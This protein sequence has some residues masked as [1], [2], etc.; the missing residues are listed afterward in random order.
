MYQASGLDRSKMGNSLHMRACRGR[1]LFL[2]WGLCFSQSCGLLLF[3]KV[4]S[5]IQSLAG[6]GG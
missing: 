5:C 3:L 1:N 4:H 2:Q 6:G